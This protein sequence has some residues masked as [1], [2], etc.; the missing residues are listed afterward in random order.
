MVGRRQRATPAS[1]DRGTTSRQSCSSE[2]Q[3]HWFHSRAE[4]IR[5]CLVDQGKALGGQNAP[6][7]AAGRGWRRKR[8]PPGRGRSR[9]R[10][11]TPVPAIS[12]TKCRL[13]VTAGP[14]PRRPRSTTEPTQW[15]RRRLLT[16]LCWRNAIRAAPASPAT[17]PG[18]STALSISIE[19]GRNDT[20]HQRADKAL[21][22]S[23]GLKI[24]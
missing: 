12:D 8:H 22:L 10:R 1:A 3:E 18:F 16:R 4:H 9:L 20:P 6:A 11:P 2:T 23:N 24:F 21:R 15:L 13:L 17:T 5:S 14:L 19:H 7:R